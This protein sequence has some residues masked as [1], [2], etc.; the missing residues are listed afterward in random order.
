[1]PRRSRGSEQ[2]PLLEPSFPPQSHCTH[3][4]ASFEA[5]QSRFPA[6]LLTDT[7]S[8]CAA[9]PPRWI[10]QLSAPQQSL[11][12]QNEGENPSG[13]RTTTSC[14]CSAPLISDGY[15]LAQIRRVQDNL[16]FQTSFPT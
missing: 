3:M 10:R 11:S 12:L 8:R 2:A 4:V 13:A 6:S 15:V 16:I 9:L 7:G 1:M 14:I 5:G